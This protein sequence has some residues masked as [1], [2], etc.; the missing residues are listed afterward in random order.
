MTGKLLSGGIKTLILKVINIGVLF[1]VS[2]SLARILGATDYGS[3]VFIFSLLS[4]FAEPV[5]VGLRTMA[6]RHTAIF[7][8]EDSPGLLKGLY[9]RLQHF[10]LAAALV[11]LLLLAGVVWF[12]SLKGVY[13]NVWLLAAAAALPFVL[14]LNRIHDG[15]L[16]G[17]GFLTAS[18]LPKLLVRPLLLLCFVLLGWFILQRDFDA[19]WAM[20]SQLFAALCAG[21]LYLILVQRRLGEKL[22]TQPAEYRTGE[23]FRG[24]APVAISTVFFSLNTRMGILL[25]GVLLTSADTGTYHA[26]LRL[27]ELTTLAH[28]TAVVVIEPYVARLY[29]QNAIQE[30]QHKISS[31][32]RL[33]FIVSVPVAA[34]MFFYGDFFLSLF[35]PE[36]K[37][38]APALA[39]LA[40]S[41]LTTTALGFPAMLLNM[42]NHASESLRGHIFGAVMHLG[43]SLLLVPELGITGAAWAAFVSVTATRLFLMLRVRQLLKL[44]SS[45]F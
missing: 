35:G 37:S 31:T 44:N 11:L 21:L 33:V 14:G 13:Y 42:T 30:L 41:Q 25:V 3:Y 27:A 16:R 17:A 28:A 26:A 7:I 8:Q 19:G 39:I 22:K 34:I 4:L 29:H 9:V 23:W 36:F 6:L 32:S 5:F 1:L 10:M 38:A 45:I 43:L 18:Q 40:A 20:S 15:M 2:V 24:S 12:M